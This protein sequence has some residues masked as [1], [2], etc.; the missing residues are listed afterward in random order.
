MV[1]VLP[2]PTSVPS[3]FSVDEVVEP[4]EVDILK[5]LLQQVFERIE[6]EHLVVVLDLLDDLV[7]YIVEGIGHLS[8]KLYID[9]RLSI[10]SDS[11]PTF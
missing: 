7:L 8:I 10:L 5:V 11:T 2:P 1:E 9:C 4:R 6:A 3:R